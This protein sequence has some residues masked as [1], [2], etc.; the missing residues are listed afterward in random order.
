MQ[1]RFDYDADETGPYCKDL[2]IK[3]ELTT[4]SYKMNEDRI[5]ILTYVNSTRSHIL[6]LFMVGESR[7]LSAFK[8]IE[9][10]SVMYKNW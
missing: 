9:N 7:K 10:F 3:K 1:D 2:L 6:S 4:L 5:T 8:N